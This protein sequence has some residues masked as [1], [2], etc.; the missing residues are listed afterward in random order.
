MNIQRPPIVTVLGHVDHGKTTL[1]DSIRK[2]HIADREAGGI[3]QSIG[4]STIETLDGKITF[5][6]TPGHAIFSDMRARGAQIADLAILVVAADDGPMPQTREAL[7]YIKESNTDFLVAFTKMDLPNANFERAQSQMEELGVLFEARGGNTPFVKIAAKKGEGISELLELII[8]TSQLKE[9]VADPDGDLDAIV[10]ETNKDKRGATASAIV[11]NGTLKVGNTIYINEKAERV[12]GLFDEQNNS[13]NV[14]GPGM[15]VLIIGFSDLPSVGDVISSTKIEAKKENIIN[16]QNNVYIKDKIGDKLPIILKAK[17]Q[18][19]LEA[20]SKAISEKD[21]II[22][23]S[24]V[25]D[26]TENDVFLAKS[27]NSRIFVFEAQVSGGV[28]RLA[29]T[30][31]IQIKAYKIVYELL[32]D[33]E[34]I[35]KKGQDLVLGKAEILAGFPFDG[36]LVAGVKIKEGVISKK[37]KLTLMRGEKIIGEVKILSIRKQKDEVDQVSQ[38]EECGILFSPQLEFLV[39]DMLLSVKHGAS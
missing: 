3:T 36:R 27:S 2:S 14:A 22:M 20:I 26:V 28:K 11:R 30:E 24:S 17:T 15:P 23:H 39:G 32:N 34:E 8:L 18:G 19:S 37:D 29:D 6:D 25:G 13:I 5:I 33:L 4:A 9:I 35:I 1:L 21:V 12:R 38:G 31:G 7:K 16:S 10:I